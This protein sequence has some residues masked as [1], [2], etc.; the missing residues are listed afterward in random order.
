[1]DKVAA[2]TMDRISLSPYESQVAQRLQYVV[3]QVMTTHA[4]APQD[5]VVRVLTERLRGMGINPNPRE[6]S[7]IA[8]SIAQL[9]KSR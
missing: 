2:V 1:M 5:D 4:G 7:Q 9:P 8:E 6:I 3:A